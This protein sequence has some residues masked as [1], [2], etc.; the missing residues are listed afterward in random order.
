M[1]A[2]A[3]RGRVQAAISTGGASPGLARAIK[4]Q[5]A[6][7]LDPAYAECA[8]IVAGARR[9][10]ID[11]GAPAEQWRPRLE[12]LLDGRLLRAAREQGREAA[13]NLAERIMQDGAD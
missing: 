10:A 12:R 8:E 11:S 9:R 3:R 7:W 5:F 2:V 1:P 13:K 6:Q 4:E